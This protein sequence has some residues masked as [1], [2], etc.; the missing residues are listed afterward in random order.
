M[1]RLV[2]TVYLG[3]NSLNSTI[4]LYTIILNDFFVQDSFIYDRLGLVFFFLFVLDHL[5]LIVLFG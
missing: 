2:D 5:D 3:N 1:S 4:F